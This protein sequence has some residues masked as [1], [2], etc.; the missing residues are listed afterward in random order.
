MLDNY[1]VKGKDKISKSQL[2][3]AIKVRNHPNVF[4]SLDNPLKGEVKQLKNIDLN[5]LLETINTMSLKHGGKI[6][7]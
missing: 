2:K 3:S 7:I 6:N 1:L 5:K 4:N